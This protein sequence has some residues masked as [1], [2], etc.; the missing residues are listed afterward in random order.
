VIG[1][2]SLSP[3]DLFLGA[4]YYEAFNTRKDGPASATL[5]RQRQWDYGSLEA[6]LLNA[7]DGEDDHQLNSFKVCGL[8][9]RIAELAFPIVFTRLHGADAGSRLR[10][11][12]LEYVRQL[13][14]PWRL[15]ARPAPP[16]KY[17]WESQDKRQYDVKCNLFLRGYRRKKGTVGLRGLLID[18]S[19][20]SAQSFPGFV[21]TDTSDDSCSWVYVGQYEPAPGIN[22]VGD[23]VLP[24]WF[25]LPDG[26][27]HAPSIDK[28]GFELGMQLLQGPTLRLGWQLACRQKAA[29]P[30]GPRTIPE[31]LFD[32]LID[33]CLRNMEGRGA[34]LEVALWEALTKTTLD[35]CSRCDPRD[36]VDSCLGLVTQLLD[37]RALPVRLPRIDGTPLLCS[38]IEQVLRPLNR[39]WDK[40]K[41]P[42]CG[43]RGSQPGNIKLSITEMTSRGTVY[44]QLKCNRCDSARNKATL[45]AHCYRPGCSPYPLIIGKNPVCET[46]QHLVCDWVDQGRVRCKCCKEGCV[47]GQQTP[48][49][50]FA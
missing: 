46:C 40:I 7:D 43:T 26:V 41:C 45:I 47:G 44:G 49:E 3:E 13:P 48:K 4:C 50:D 28:T 36:S 29:L 32:Q 15:G 5:R 9:P 31:S 8:Q 16:P 11:L 12:N 24:F 23:R 6:S 2:G 17:D 34:C 10:D 22:K 30:Q 33:A 21:F 42:D 18:R 20:V 1:Y 14:S 38:W 19:K 39:Y 35:A 25:Q 27:R 37:N